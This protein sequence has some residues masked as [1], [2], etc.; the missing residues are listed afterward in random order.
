M[1][2]LVISEGEVSSKVQGTRAA[3]Y[4]V[5]IRVL[6]LSDKDWAQVEE[7]MSQ[8]A[9]F[10]AK[11]L[12][13]EM[14]EAIE[15]AFAQC[16]LALFPTAARDLVTGCS[17]P[18][19]ANP[20][21]HVAAT[22]FLLAEAFDEDP[23]LIFQ[24]RGRSRE[25]LLESLRS[26][27]LGALRSNTTGGPGQPSAMIPAPPTIDIVPLSE[28]LESFWDLQVPG[29]CLS[30][31]GFIDETSELRGAGPPVDPGAILR[32]LEPLGVTVRS[33]SLTELLAPM[34]G[35]AAGEALDLILGRPDGG[36]GA[37]CGPS[38]PLTGSRDRS[39]SIEEIE[40]ER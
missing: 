2:E 15:E 14:P 19:W 1:L 4:K 20:C 23:F 22:Y 25:E 21:K 36:K 39:N 11:L 34:Y 37:R 10:L 9:I 28:S 7:A 33:K 32:E 24:W 3:P 16:Q 12:A 13:G 18:D 35:A 27:H 17:C 26:R 5:T 31:A 30:D 8:R 38:H 40:R 6:P 29:T